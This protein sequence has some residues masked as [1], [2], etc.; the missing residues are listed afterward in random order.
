MVNTG[1]TNSRARESGGGAF[2]GVGYE[3]NFESQSEALK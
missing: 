3:I 1:V 2:H